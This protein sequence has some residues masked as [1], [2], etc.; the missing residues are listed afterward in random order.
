MQGR[1]LAHHL[2]SSISGGTDYIYWQTSTLHEPFPV[3][4]FSLLIHVDNWKR[5]FISRE[6]GNLLMREKISIRLFFLR[7][8]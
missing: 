7:N 1:V 4:V 2:L 3:I 6:S 8:Q 5:I